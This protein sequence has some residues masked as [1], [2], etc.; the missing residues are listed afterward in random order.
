MN[1]NAKRLT[2]HH[3]SMHAGRICQPIVGMNNIKLLLA[4]NDT[5]Y[6]REI[7]DLVM[8]VSRI[9]SGKLHTPQI[10]YIQI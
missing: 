8:Q 4:S 3:L 5:R 1:M 7:I 6:N 2:T 9:P 10:I